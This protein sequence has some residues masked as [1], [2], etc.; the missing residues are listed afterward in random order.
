MTGDFS[1]GI[2]VLVVEDEWLIGEDLKAQLE[3]LGCA[4]MGPAPSCSA[5]LEAIW[6][7]KPD[8]AFVDTQLGS[9]T[10]E[11]VLEECE[12]QGIP[13]IIMSGHSASDLPL[14]CGDRQLL[15]KPY[16]L[17][18]VKRAFSAHLAG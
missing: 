10:C 16:Q 17:A 1:L 14:F 9:E 2:R 15:S 5:A 4:V 12:R 3:D 11:A 18:D 7:A 8:L 13:V 6:S